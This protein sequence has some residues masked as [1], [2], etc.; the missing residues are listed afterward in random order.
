MTK[1][2]T[3]TTGVPSVRARRRAVPWLRGAVLAALVCAFVAA[4]VGATAGRADAEPPVLPL[5]PVDSA[6]PEIPLPPSTPDPTDNPVPLPLPPVSDWPDQLP[7]PPNP[8]GPSPSVPAQPPPIVVDPDHP[9]APPPPAQQQGPQ[10]QTEST[11]CGW[12]DVVCKAGQAINEWFTGLVTSA[13]D[14]VLDLVGRT[15]MTTPNLADN[16]QIAQLWDITRW[17]ANSLFILFVIM[18]GIVV[19]SHETLQTRVT[20]KETLPRI[21]VGFVAVNA[22]LSLIGLAVNFANGIATGILAGDSSGGITTGVKDELHRQL[23][24]GGIFM[25][26]VAL[27]VL[28]LAVVLLVLF[29]LRITITIVIVVAGPLALVCHASPYTEGIA[30]LWWRALFGVLAIQILQAITL[31]VFVKVFFVQGTSGPGSTELLGVSGGL[32]NLVISVVLLLI[33][34]KIPS[35]VLQQIGLG[36]RS[37]VASIVKYALLAKGLGMLGVG[38]SAAATTARRGSGGAS[39][40]P[41]G[42][43]PARVL[44]G[45]A[46]PRQRGGATSGAGAQRMAH[47]AARAARERAARAWAAPTRMA[48]E[49]RAASRDRRQPLSDGGFTPASG[50]YVP[51]SRATTSSAVSVAAPIESTRW[52]SPDPRRHSPTT[53]TRSAGS[54][55]AATASQA[56]DRTPGAPARNTATTPAARRRVSPRAHAPT[57]QAPGGSP[58]TPSRSARKSTGGSGHQLGAPRAGAAKPTPR[59]PKKGGR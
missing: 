32:M 16:P 40:R 8:D 25:V 23:D 34:I 26:L 56:R 52:G 33:L 9:V 57:F 29:V 47:G 14:P 37:Q 48:R 28:V 27:V 46:S 20:L 41:Q 49:A 18:G 51:V 42:H 36:G 17:V 13:M 15:S 44:A 43:G 6:D 19:A 10:A 54:S 11:D 59:T 38:K 1:P 55:R 39:T 3:S 50:A 22:S 21:V 53:G 7:P 58:S 5:P 4:L 12:L 24:Q 35:W 31:I 2:T 30:K 45:G